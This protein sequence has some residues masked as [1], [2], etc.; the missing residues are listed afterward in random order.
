[1][2]LISKRAR[3]ALH[4][5]AYIAHAGGAGPV[6]FE[7]ILRY[8]KAYAGRLT[9]SP[10][11]I[12]KI[13][14]EVSRAGLTEA[15]SG[16]HGGYQLARDPERMSLIEVIEALDGPRTSACCLLSVG[17]CP[18]QKVC[19]VRTISQEAE[20]AFYARFERETVAS[21]ARRMSFP[22]LGQADGPPGAA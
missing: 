21:L 20:A 7:E 15:A 10:S 12:A 22:D 9:L 18:E 14:Q 6:S 16:P 8:L 13:F 3:Y 11:Y 5:L 1:M 19:G 2:S 17:D 4:G